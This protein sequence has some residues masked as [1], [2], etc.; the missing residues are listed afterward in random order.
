MHVDNSS[1]PIEIGAQGKCNINCKLVQAVQ[2]MHAIREGPIGIV[3][4]KLRK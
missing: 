4:S 3:Q 1:Y 2:V